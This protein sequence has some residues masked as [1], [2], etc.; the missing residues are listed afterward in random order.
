[1]RK[2]GDEEIILIFQTWEVKCPQKI[3]AL[4]EATYHH[5][6]TKLGDGKFGFILD[7]AL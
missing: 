1:V 6:V 4:G 2:Y 7:G 3:K 5:D